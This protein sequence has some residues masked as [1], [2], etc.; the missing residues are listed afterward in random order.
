MSAPTAVTPRKALA[1]L[2]SALLLSGVLA[3]LFTPATARADSAPIDVTDPRTPTTVTADALP[4]V[5]INGVAW[6]QVVVGNTVYVGGRFTSARPAGAPAGVQESARSNLL[7][8]DIRTGNLIT[9]FAPAVNGQV[10]ALAASPDGSRV[11]IG[12]DFYSVNGQDRSR[13]A[14][15]DTATGQLVSTFRPAVTG[16]VRAIAATSSTVYLGGGFSAVGGVGR[17]RLAAVSASNGS[18]L[19][20]APQPG[21]GPAGWGRASDPATQTATTN[22]VMSIVVAG[23]SG[24]VVVAG[25]FYYMNG[26]QNIGVAAVDGTTGANRPFAINAL[27]R[28]FGVNAAVYSLSTDGTNVYGA[29]YDFYGPGSLEGPFAAR[30]DGGAP[31]WFAP[32]RGDTYSTFPFGGALYTAGHA[33]DCRSLASFPEQNPRHHWFGTA[34]SIAPTQTVLSGNTFGDISYVGQPAPTLDAW[35][36]RFVAGTFTGQYQAGWSVSGNSDYVVFAGEF[37]S[38]NGVGQQGLVRFARAD[39]A[40]NRV[41]PRGDTIAFTPTATMVPGGV[42]VSWRAVYDDDNAELTYRVYRDSETAAPACEVVRPSQWWN[43][44]TWSCTDTGATAGAHR[45]L[46]T[47]T[48]AAG[49]RVAS[50]WVD[51]TVG[52]ANSSAA[53]AY[54]TVVARDGALDHWSLGETSGLLAYDRL[55]AADLRINSGV[56][57]NQAG[58]VAGDADR[59][60]AFGG[61]SSGYLATTTSVAAPQSFSVEAWFSTTSR[62]GGKIVGF[63]N[64]S[65][66]TSSTYD[67]QIS[68]DTTGRISLGIR[69]TNGTLVYVTSTATFNDGQ[70]HHVVGSLSHLGMQLYVDGVLVGSRADVTRAAQYNG[71]WRVGGDSMAT[72]TGA[73][74]FNGRIDEVAVY[75]RAL[76]AAQV[77]AHETTGRTGAPPNV[78]PTAAFTVSS[79][80]LAAAFDASASADVDGRVTA[81]AWDF[82]DGRTG[83]G[84]TVRHTYA[85]AGTYPVRLTVTDDRGGEGTLVRDVTVTAPPVGPGSIAADT[86]GREVAQGWGTADRGGVWSAVGAT[87]VTGGAGQLAPAAGASA[88][89]TLGSVDRMDVAVQVAVTLPQAATGGGTYLSLAAQSVGA[90]DYRVKMRFRADGQAEI[91]LVR[92]VNGQETVLDGYMLAG[93]Y[94]P[95]TSL[96]VRFETSGAFPTTL[97]VKTWR[98]GTAEPAA[99]NLTRTDATAAL[100]R[101]GAVQIS[102]YV[103]ASA[104][105]ASVVRVDD[106]RVEPAGTV[107]Q[108]PNQAPVAAFTAT[109]S[110]LT[111]SVDGSGSTD[112][113]AVTGYAWDFGNGQTATGATASHTYATAGTYTVRLTVTD[114]AGLTGTTTRSVTVTAPPVGGPIAAD[115]FGRTVA[116]GWGTAETGGA[117]STAGATSVTDGAGQL[118]GAKGAGSQARLGSVSVTDSTVQATLTMPQLATGGGFYVSVASRSVGLTDYRVKMRFRADGQVEVMLVRT[119]DDVETILGGYL[120]SGGYTAGTPLALRFEVSGTAPTTLQVK[121]WRAG[122]AEPAAWGLTRTDA[123]AGLQRAGALSL[124]T[125]TSGS[126]TATATVRIDDLR[127]DA[128]GTAQPE[129]VNQAPVAAFTATTSGLTA[130][131]DGSGS[132]DDAA[133]TGYAWD[134][135]N[136]QTATGA[137]ASHTYA[138]AGTYTV[139]LTVTDAAGLTG[140]TTRSVTVTAPAPQPEPEPVNQAPVAAFTATTSGL[141]ASVD[142]SGSTDDAAVTGYAWDFG[143]GQTATG[144]TASHTYATAGTYT[145]RLTVTDAAGLTGTTT[146]S[147]TVTAPAPQPEPQVPALAADAFERQVTGGWGTADVG[148]PWFI[149]GVA[150]NASVADGAGRLAGPVGQGTAAVLTQFSRQDVAVQVSLTVPQAPTGGGTYVSLAARNVGLTDY[151]VKLRFRADGQVEVMLVRNVNGQETILGGY[152]LAGGYRPGT[153]LH[154]RYDVGGATTTTFSVK[155]WAEGT[156]EPAAWQLTRTDATAALQRP[157]TVGFEHYVTASATAA[158][159]IRFE[160]LWIGE[161]GTAPAAP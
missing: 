63:G 12:G 13:V 72:G 159:P 2:L 61:T 92:V 60:F 67:R 91:M 107:A 42:R 134:F 47:A 110:G 154:V 121:V 73:A 106:L 109:V 33:H 54:A 38:V 111:A 99:W 31:V 48:D 1:G 158:S 55:G 148:G 64:V 65:S 34:M 113:A 141:T 136:G 6:A 77:A 16:Q 135:G 29:T 153:T 50:S 70:Y 101:S 36:P 71:F 3:G 25:R 100:Q 86:F 59:A 97:K 152:L 96:T 137:T 28:N 62:N 17:N 27:I 103:S 35:Q 155:A 20:W 138:T 112:D 124:F 115:T 122:T 21:A 18:L 120:L 128:P 32:C 8:Y 44:P 22:D 89:A 161:S 24:Q 49:N 57:L 140:T 133:V 98:T 15:F 82:G 87:S 46:V 139:R 51:A 143:N 117:W 102:E 94:T 147:V 118:G 4:T 108:A 30:A 80:D 23:P 83:S 52:A 130:N 5:Q 66:G 144:A 11:Y 123:T 40:P 151:R 104:T 10:L 157:G 78:V 126:A 39:K 85:A 56:T 114:A 75:P 69:Q 105:R 93:G 81:Y 45:Y 68:M 95:G 26:T 41:G 129:P 9:S 14:A 150:A 19:P 58:A 119:V 116:S 53:R 131:V 149:H 43:R 132:T 88:S 125:Y 142:G 79:T 160:Q 37:P 84:A 145:V 146:R 74:W 156:A 127:V 90:N 7:A 76:T